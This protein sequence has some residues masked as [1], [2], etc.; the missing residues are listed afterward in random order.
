MEL[1]FHTLFDDICEVRHLLDL[2]AA[3]M[4]PIT[5]DREDFPPKT[6]HYFGMANEEAA[7]AE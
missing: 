1:N 6:I 3:R 4:L 5:H 2:F 7:R